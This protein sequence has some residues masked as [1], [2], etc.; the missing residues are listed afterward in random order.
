MYSLL[1]V[2]SSSAQDATAIKKEIS[3]DVQ[4]VNS[5]V[6]Y[7]MTKLNAEEF[8]DEVP[9]GG[10]EL[11]GYF[12]SGQIKRIRQWV[13]LSNGNRTMEFYFKS[14]KL[15]FVYEKMNS[16][17]YNVR[18]QTFDNTRTEVTFIGRYYFRD[19]KLIDYETTGHNRFEDDSINPEKVLVDEANERVKKLKGKKQ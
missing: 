11:I 3:K 19:D 6:G 10:G 2:L 1:I 9:D 17:I 5:A 18:K 16:F 12:K 7:K 14:E 15:M 8:L 4:L 13:G